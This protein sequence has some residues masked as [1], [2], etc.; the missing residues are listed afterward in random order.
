M[1]LHVTLTNRIM[2]KKLYQQPKTEFVQ[3]ET[4]ALLVTSLLTDPNPGDDL[5]GA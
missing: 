1:I 5:W 4:S 2:E 3:L